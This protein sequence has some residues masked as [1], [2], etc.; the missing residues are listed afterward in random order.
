MVANKSNK[1]NKFKNKLNYFIINSKPIDKIL[2]YSGL[3]IILLF[4]SL[5]I[6]QSYD[7]FQWK[8]NNQIFQTNEWVD[9]KED[10][11]AP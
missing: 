5:I 4:S 1:L 7:L 9:S 8:V 3:V 10:D 2:L 6:N 11:E